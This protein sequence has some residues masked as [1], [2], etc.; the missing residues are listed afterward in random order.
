MVSQQPSQILD[1]HINNN[2]CVKVGRFEIIEKKVN[3]K[4]P[5][6]SLEN[7]SALLKGNNKMTNLSINIINQTTKNWSKETMKIRKKENHTFIFQNIE[8]S[9]L[10]ILAD[11]N[12]TTKS[13]KLIMNNSTNKILDKNIESEKFPNNTINIEKNSLIKEF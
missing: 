11:I 13:S 3:D 10:C 9:N 1:N 5:K 12:K 8:E 2:S 4:D 7:E 6:A